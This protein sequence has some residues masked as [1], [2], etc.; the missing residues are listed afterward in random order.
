MA[1]NQGRLD[2]GNTVTT[3]VTVNDDD[4]ETV[5]LRIAADEGVI[6]IISKDA[7]VS[8]VTPAMT[9]I[10]GGVVEVCANLVSPSGGT[11]VPITIVFTW[12]GG[13]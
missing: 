2:L 11:S 9:T 13:M 6:I 7:V 5:T 10:E 8:M 3:T 12:S 4:G 1:L